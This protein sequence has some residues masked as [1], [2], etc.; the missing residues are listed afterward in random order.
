MQ[1]ANILIFIL[2]LGFCYGKLRF[3]LY[4][5]HVFCSTDGWCIKQ[6]LILNKK[7]YLIIWNKYLNYSIVAKFCIQNIHI[8]V[9]KIL[10][11]I[12]VSKLCRYKNFSML[13]VIWVL[14][15]YYMSSTVNPIIINKFNLYLI[16]IYKRSGGRGP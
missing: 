9:N 1:E 11:Y 10:Q 14:Y 2:R 7:R 15:E 8:V 5:I 12:T 3:I 6:S 16:Y 13:L 4:V